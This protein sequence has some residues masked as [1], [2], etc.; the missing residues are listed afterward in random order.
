M[1]GPGALL[2]GVG[3]ADVARR[4]CREGEDAEVGDCDGAGGQGRDKV[5]A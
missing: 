3:C 5:G 2:A 1:E 4:G